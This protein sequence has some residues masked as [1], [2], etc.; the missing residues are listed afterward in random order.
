MVH[1]IA[2]FFLRYWLSIDAMF[3]SANVI[4]DFQKTRFYVHLIF[5][6]IVAVSFFLVSIT[7][8]CIITYTYALFS[9]LF[10]KLPYSSV[11]PIQISQFLI[12]SFLI[13]WMRTFKILPFS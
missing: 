8:A 12:N 7:L 2:S 5:Q 13:M 6:L 9:Y 10:T 4:F 11:F 3:V 1:L